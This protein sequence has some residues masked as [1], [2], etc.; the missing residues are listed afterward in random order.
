MPAPPTTAH[1]QLFRGDRRPVEPGKEVAG[2]RAA[3]ERVL[4]P[5]DGL[6]DRV[7]EDP[8]RAPLALD[9][10]RLPLGEVPDYR[11]VGDRAAAAVDDHVAGVGFGH[12]LVAVLP[13]NDVD[14]LAGDD[15][16]SAGE[17]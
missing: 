13:E 14:L 12:L 10:N 16:L 3:V 1:R 8:E 15:E 4:R 7:Q 17:D 9:E 6:I 5:V 2:P 11:R